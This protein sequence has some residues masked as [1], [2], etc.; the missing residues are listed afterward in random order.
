M[1][2]PDLLPI[3]P[4]DLKDESPAVLS[5]ARIVGLLK[6]SAAHPYYR[7]KPGEAGA[8]LLL[9]NDMIA[10]AGRYRMTDDVL[11]QLDEIK[12]ILRFWS[13]DSLSPESVQKLMREHAGIYL[14]TET[15]DLGV[16][17]PVVVLNHQGAPD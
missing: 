9:L 8:L 15:T 11:G 12:A 3:L 14:E 4:G 6:E 2:D 5:D 1:I 17:I 10:Q 16:E 7:N 13:I